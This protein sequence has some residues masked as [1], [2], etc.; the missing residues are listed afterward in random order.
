MELLVKNIRLAFNA[1]FED[2]I[3]GILRKKGISGV[4][5]RRIFKR[6]VDARKKNNIIFV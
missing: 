4:S 6:S 2:N 1:D 3:D 5:Y